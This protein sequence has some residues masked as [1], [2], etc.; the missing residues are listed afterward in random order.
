MA[1][2]KITAA[3]AKAIYETRTIKLEGARKAA[4][5]RIF[6][7]IKAE[8]GIPSSTR[9]KINILGEDNPE[10]LVVRDKKTLRPLLNS[11]PEPTIGV[12]PVKVVAPAPV[13]KPAPVKAAKPVAKPAPVKAAKPVAKPAQTKT[14]KPL[15]SPIR[16]DK[17]CYEVRPSINGK[18][19]RLG[20]ASS[21]KEKEAM[22]A[23]FKAMQG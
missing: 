6:S 22:I 13:A 19:V 5:K 4:K 20:Y 2:I 3:V 21:V 18:K 10:Y 8:H 1:T 11:L 15:G 17:F 7:A 14:A 9:I 16:S 12:A 23:K